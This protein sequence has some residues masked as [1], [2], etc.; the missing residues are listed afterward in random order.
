MGKTPKPLRIYVD[1]CLYP[2][3][4]MDALAEQGHEVHNMA[5]PELVDGVESLEDAGYSLDSMIRY[6]THEYDLIFSP[7]AWMCTDEHKKYLPI[8]LKA[9]RLV[10]YPPK[11]KKRAK[12]KKST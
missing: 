11:E 5:L 1:P 6:L 4:E 12:T 7:H 8:A 10:R 3:P 2:W 9:A